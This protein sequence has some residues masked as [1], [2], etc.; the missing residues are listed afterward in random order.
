MHENWDQFWKLIEPVHLK[1]RA[2][3]RKLMNDQEEGDDLYQDALV[4]ALSGFARLRNIETFRTWLYRIIVNEFRNRRRR[5]RWKR[6]V[7]LTVEIE[8]SSGGKNPDAVHAARRAL[9]IA[10]Q[11]VTADEKALIM[12]FEI[13][14]WSVL[15]LAELTGH[16]IS[17]VKVKLHRVRYKMRKALYRHY[18]KSSAP[19]IR[20]EMKSED[21]ICVVAKPG[22]N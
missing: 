20:K 15:E 9:E 5:R 11:A 8:E 17:N 22:K 3:C 6:F 19:T 13:E 2:Y 16:S 12:L 10:F 21:K 18:R 4:G 14:G 1:A 7:P